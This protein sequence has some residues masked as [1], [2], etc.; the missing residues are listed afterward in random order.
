MASF[1]H[2]LV[3]GLMVF[4]MLSFLSHMRLGMQ[5]I[6]ED[7]V[8]DASA[9]RAAMLLNNLFVGVLGIAALFAIAKMSLGY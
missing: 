1:D 2:P 8:H 4:S 3:S 7:Y 6:I 5:V 9:F